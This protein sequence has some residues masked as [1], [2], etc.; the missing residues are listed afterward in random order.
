MSPRASPANSH[1]PG[2][3]G[4]PMAGDAVIGP[5]AANLL[6]TAPVPGS[7]EYSIPPWSP[8]R[9]RGLGAN[10]GMP[11]AGSARAVRDNTLDHATEPSAAFSAYSVPPTATATRTGV[12]SMVTA[13]PLEMSPPAR[14]A[15][16]RRVPLRSKAYSAWPAPTITL[17]GSGGKQASSGEVT[18][19]P[20]ATRH[21]SPPARLAAAR[22]P[23]AEPTTI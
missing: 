6:T 16:H 20:K 8:T 12:G 14:T 5:P 10:L 3:L 7:T 9:I 1:G 19:A 17:H 18:G 15:A 4:S 21:S 2:R 23:S 13:P 22:V 11:T